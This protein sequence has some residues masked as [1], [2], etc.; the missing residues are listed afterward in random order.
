VSNVAIEIYRIWLV[1]PALPG[2]ADRAL[3]DLLARHLGRGFELEVGPHG[4]PGVVGGGVEFNVTHS[5]MVALV[6]ISDGGPIGVDVEQH[7]KL[8]D[9]IAFARRFFSPAET[10]AVRADPDALFRWWA[11]KEAWLK[12]QGVGIRMPLGEVDVREQPPGWLLADLDVAPG[13]S[14]AVAREGGPAE[15][16]LVDYDTIARNTST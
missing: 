10:E 15:I 13:Y 2:C 16:R 9:P 6:A 4:K 1:A 12:A 5:G 8:A 7:R 14:A 11:R 3:R